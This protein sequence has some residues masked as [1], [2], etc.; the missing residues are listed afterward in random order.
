MCFIMIF[1]VEFFFVYNHEMELVNVKK[2]PTKQYY[3]KL[4]NHEGFYE[5][6]N[7]MATL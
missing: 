7:I 1:N 3:L 4:P 6:T 2:Q 5:S